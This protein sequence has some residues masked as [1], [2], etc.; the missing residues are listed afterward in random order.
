MSRA[1]HHNPRHTTT[2][3]R[4]RAIIA[5]NEPPCHICGQPIDYN[6][7]WLNPG[8]YVVDHV[9]PISRGGENTLENKRAAHRACNAAKAAKPLPEAQLQAAPTTTTTLLTW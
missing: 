2:R 5:A 1:H 7:P 9:V 8:A 6:L 3:D 4:H